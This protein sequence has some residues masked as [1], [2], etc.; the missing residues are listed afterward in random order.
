MSL[1]TPGGATAP[2]AADLAA[3]SATTAKISAA[4]SEHD[5]LNATADAQAI[6]DPATRMRVLAA[7][8]VK[9]AQPEIAMSTEHELR[10]FGQLL[11]PNPRS[12]KHFVNT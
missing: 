4:T 2:S 5:I 8:A 7:A 12:V 3:Q 10:P 6:Q 9:I 11:A 1:L